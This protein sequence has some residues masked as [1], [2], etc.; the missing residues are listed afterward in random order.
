MAKENLQKASARQARYFNKKAKN[1][2]FSVGDKVLILLPNK[3]NKLQMTWRGP[4]VVTDKVNEHNYKIQIG[5]KEKLYHANVLKEYVTR[6]SEPET[7]IV[8]TVIIEEQD[9]ISPNSKSDIPLVNLEQKEGTKDVKIDNRLNDRQR[10]EAVETV[11]KFT[12]VFSDLPGSATLEECSIR[13][14]DDTPIFVRQ[15]PLPYAKIETI[16]KEIDSMLKLGVIEPAASP[17]NAPVV[18]VQKKDGSNRFCIDYRKLNQATIFDA[19]P[20]PD[21]N[22]LF[23]KLSGKKYFSKLD[24][25]KGYWQIPMNQA[26]KEKTAFTTAQGQFQWTMMPFGLKNAGAV[27]SKMMRK[28]L[29]PCDQNSVSN[30]MDDL[31]IA[32][33]TWEEHLMILTQVL[34]RLQECNLTAK[35]SK[36]HIG[37][38]ELS[39][40]GHE[41]GQGTVKPEEDKI[42]K[43]SQAQPPRTKKEL[44]AFLGL[45]GYYRKFVPNFATIALP[46]TDCTKKGQPEKIIW[47]EACDRAFTTLKRKLSEKPII[48]IPDT[49][50]PFV[51]RTDAS[52]KGLG[53][54]LLQDQGQGLQPIVYASK[55]LAGA[56]CNYAI[57]EKECLAIV[58]GIKKF[59]PYLF[60]TTFTIETDHQPLQYL[61]KSR[62]ENGRLMRWA[63]QL[64]QYHFHVKVIP[65]K[66]NVGADYLSRC[67]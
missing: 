50:K 41:V 14:E 2:K 63:I 9:D 37:Y 40:L 23:S 66:D 27:F 53:A 13:Q 56:E 49:K 36:C 60:G 45:A 26:D 35:P 16:G 1:R 15:Y 48:C 10:K 43:I 47:S 11:E 38:Q 31:L 55:K 61:R 7:H 39:F 42:Q 30:F 18:L 32:T 20:M 8:A 65:G 22:Q 44:R 24:L 12:K 34:S 54:V 28:L 46:L 25:T 58:W 6:D 19:E 52:D 67:S 59:Q 29:R 64:Q 33:E 4:Y 51:L 3:N 62:T 5:Q 17:Y 57:I 21:V